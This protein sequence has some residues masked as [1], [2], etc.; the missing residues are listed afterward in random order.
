MSEVKN[1]DVMYW[2]YPSRAY[3]SEQ[4]A[5]WFDKYLSNEFKTLKT[6]QKGNLFYIYSPDGYKAAFFIHRR[7]GSDMELHDIIPSFHIYV[8]PFANNN[9][10]VMGKDFFTFYFSPAQKTGDLIQPY[11]FNW[12]GSEQALYNGEFGCRPV[13]INN[14][15]TPHYCST[16]IEYNNWEVPD[17]Y[18]FKF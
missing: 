10:T 7:S 1:T 6:E 11:K 4:V 14:K 13:D 9:G 18:P 5:S 17:N 8:Y 12:D 16:L 2:E 3:D 15:H